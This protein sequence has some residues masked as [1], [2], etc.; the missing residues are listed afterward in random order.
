M[1]FSVL[2]I[3]KEGVLIKHTLFSN[4]LYIDLL[5]FMYNL[6]HLFAKSDGIPLRYEH[7][8]VE[9]IGNDKDR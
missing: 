9:C 6:H 5:Q 3:I 4:G 8:P 1:S 7:N 2:I